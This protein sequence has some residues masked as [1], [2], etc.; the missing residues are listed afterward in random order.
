MKLKFITLVLAG[1]MLS[2][3]PVFAAEEAKPSQPSE[4][5][6]KALREQMSENAAFIRKVNSDTSMTPEQKKAA[7]K[8]FIQ[9]QNEK[10]A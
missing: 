7:I 3:M 2:S 6:M 1:L 8:E 9:A 5:T 10:H 4:E